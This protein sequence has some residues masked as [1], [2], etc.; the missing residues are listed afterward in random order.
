MFVDGLMKRRIAMD[1]LNKDKLVIEDIL[2]E[3]ILL[4]PITILVIMVY[5]N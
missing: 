4:V 3:I 2:P 5:I 1:P